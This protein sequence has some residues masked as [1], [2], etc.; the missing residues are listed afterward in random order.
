MLPEFEYQGQKSKV[1]VTGDKKTK[2][3][4]S[5][6]MTMHGKTTRAL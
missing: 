3:G 1:N 5:S 2:D 6:P 4:E